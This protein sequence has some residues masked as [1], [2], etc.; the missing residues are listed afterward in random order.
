MVGSLGLGCS[1]VRVV[2]AVGVS[3]GVETLRRE[4]LMSEQKLLGW[5]LVCS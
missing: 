3:P 1:L 2:G 4:E 5:P